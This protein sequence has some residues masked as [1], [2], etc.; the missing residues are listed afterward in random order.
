MS[1]DCKVVIG[2]NYGDEGKGLVTDYLS[3]PDTL[4][5]RFNGGAQAGH[6]VVEPGGWRHVFHHVGSGTFRGARTLLSR[7][8]ILNPFIFVKETDALGDT[9]PIYVDP[10]APVTTPYDMLLNQAVE[11]L[12][13]SARHGSCGLGINETVTRHQSLWLS[14]SHLFKERD[15]R[16]RLQQIE[17]DWLPVRARA[18]GVDVP[19]VDP[20]L[21]DAYIQACH[22]LVDRTTVCLDAEEI[23]HYMGPILF[24]GAQGLLLDEVR[25]QFPH[26]TRSRTGLTNVALLTQE[27]VD[28]YYVTRAY[29]T[30]HGAGPLPGETT[31]HPYGWTGPETNVSG[32][33]QGDFRYAPLDRH[34]LGRTIAEDLFY[35]ELPV[36]SVQ[37]AVTCL[38]QLNGKDSVAAL[39]GYPVGLRAYGPTRE[40]VRA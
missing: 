25:G 5:V 10:R 12:R 21:L 20:W 19:M 15:L 30:R 16:K 37:L 35:A 13:G 33:W 9:P 4:V 38:D 31:G 1:F 14:Y 24:E 29:L 23:A 28:V 26:V 34:Q 3:T 7:F 27:P 2:A 18:L 17:R 39:A 6:T 32:E 11:R 36:K 40:D 8:F 22:T